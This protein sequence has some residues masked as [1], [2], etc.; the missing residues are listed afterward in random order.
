MKITTKEEFMACTD[1][2]GDCWL[3]A[4][5]LDNYGYGIRGRQGKAHRLAYEIFVGPIPDG[6][7]IHHTCDVKSCVNPEH[8]EAITRAEHARLGKQAAQTHCVNGHEFT[9]ENT[10]TYNDGKN[11]ACRACNRRAVA[12]RKARLR[13]EAVR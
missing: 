2:S 8:L 9:A 1:Q 4:G 11:R 12:A 3:W 6:H 13:T 7:E 10:Y 5:Q